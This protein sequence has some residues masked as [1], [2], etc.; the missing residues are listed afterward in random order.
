MSWSG[1]VSK[2]GAAPTVLSTIQRSDTS[3]GSNVIPVGLV[4]PEVE[5]VQLPTYA[6][7]TVYLKT[8]SILL[9]SM[10]HR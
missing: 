4:T 8:L 3:D 1:P 10:T 7:P 9:L 2:F 5:M 6:P